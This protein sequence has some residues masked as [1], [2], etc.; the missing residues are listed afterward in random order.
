MSFVGEDGAVVC[1]EEEHAPE[2]MLENGDWIIPFLG[3]E[4][5]LAVYTE[6]A[7]VDIARYPSEKAKESM[8]PIATVEHNAPKNVAEKSF[9][10]AAR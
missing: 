10:R 7:W 4:R 5:P 2:S 3:D 1:G 9:F 6:N 8:F